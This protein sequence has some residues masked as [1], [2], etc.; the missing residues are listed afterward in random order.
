M[1]TGRMRW[2]V[3]VLVGIAIAAIF[4]AGLPI[5]AGVLA[6]ALFIVVA[7]MGATSSSRPQ[8]KTE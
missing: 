2:V 4:V 8:A 7:V 5:L 6:L 1:L 3:L